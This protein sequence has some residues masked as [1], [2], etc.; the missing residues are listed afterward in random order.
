M[1]VAS[2]GQILYTHTFGL[3]DVESKIPISVTDIFFYLPIVLTL[4][5]ACSPKKQADLVV[6]N[7][8]M[9]TV[10]GSFSV[11][12]AFAVKDGKILQ[13]GS[14]IDIQAAYNRKKAFSGGSRE[15]LNMSSSII[16]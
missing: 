9:Y 10:D 14:S 2:N 5:C 8:K 16:T 7:A 3:K 12:E 4:L 1:S 6:Y 11:V 13:T 15:I